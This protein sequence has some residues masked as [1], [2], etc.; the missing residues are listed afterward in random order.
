MGGGIIRGRN[1]LFTGAFSKK[2]RESELSYA[3]GFYIFKPDGSAR[4]T[5]EKQSLLGWVEESDHCKLHRD[6]NVKCR[7]DLAV[8][9]ILTDEA[10]LFPPVRLPRTHRSSL[11]ETQSKFKKCQT[12]PVGSVVQA[13]AH[14]ERLGLHGAVIDNELRAVIC[15]GLGF[16]DLLGAFLLTCS[17]A[18]AEEVAAVLSKHRKSNLYDK[19]GFRAP[20]S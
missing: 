15:L 9:E 4:T 5:P 3:A 20:P 2:A 18:S 14:S 10:A 7:A 13:L 17:T 8:F 16:V 11:M 6:A 19:S 12:A 1:S